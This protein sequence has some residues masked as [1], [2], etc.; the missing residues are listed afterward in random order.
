MKKSITHISLIAMAII[1]FLSAC[2]V[3][4]RHYRPGLHFKSEAKVPKPEVKKHDVAPEPETVVVEAEVAPEDLT[5]ETTTTTSTTDVVA[6]PEAKKTTT[7]KVAKAT[8]KPV[9]KLGDKAIA[10]SMISKKA[11]KG[12]SPKGMMADK[13]IS[14]I[15]CIFL[16]WLGIHRFY[17]GYPVSAIL[18][19]VLFVASVVLGGFVL[20]WIGYLCGILLFVWIII[21][22]IYLILDRPLFFPS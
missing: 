3:E 20:G 22:L 14:I 8:E 13:I 2:S 17:L 15:L 10:L 5:V 9:T 12:Q 1:V 11:L 18:M 21:D 6:V 7:N 19:I 16:G 4:K